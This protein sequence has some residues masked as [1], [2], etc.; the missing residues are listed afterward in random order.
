M[1]KR[2]FKITM[3]ERCYRFKSD[4]LE[5]HA[6]HQP[7]VYE[8]VMFNEQMEPVVLFV[9]LA[10][11]G[12]IYDALT[13]HLLGDLRPSPK[14]LFETSKDIYFDFIASADIESPEEYKDI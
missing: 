12:T 3:S 9:G 2:V 7:G 4:A 13:G 1:E 6:P 8:F 14:L 5:S 11:P 10:Y